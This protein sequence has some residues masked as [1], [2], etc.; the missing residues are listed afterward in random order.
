MKEIVGIM[1]VMIVIKMIRGVWYVIMVTIPAPYATRSITF[2]ENI[3]IEWFF[4]LRA[5]QVSSNKRDAD[6]NSFI[7]LINS[8]QDF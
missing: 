3:E 5:R 4:S 1:I 2:M 8:N 6:F 7:S